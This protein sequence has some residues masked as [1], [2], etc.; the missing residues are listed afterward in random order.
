MNNMPNPD[1]P[2]CGCK[3]FDR[4]AKDPAFPV[5]YD[6]RMN[7]FHLITHDGRGQASFYHCPFCGGRAPKSLRATFFADVTDEESRRLFLLT[8]HILNKEQIIK[9]LGEPHQDFEIS[10]GMTSAGSDTEPKETFIGGR[11][12]VYE[13]LSDTADVN[14][15]IDRYGKLRFSFTG[16]YI[17]PQRQTE[18]GPQ[19]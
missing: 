6:A 8:Q 17:G 9:E 4:A 15:R 5:V 2:P 18:S 13:N 19:E 1:A 16:K 12:L 10:G 11:R 3:W 14:V 7:E